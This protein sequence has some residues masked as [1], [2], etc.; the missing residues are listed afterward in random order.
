[1][2]Y[3]PYWNISGFEGSQCEYIS[4]LSVCKNHPCQN[5]GT[6]VNTDSS[7]LSLY[8]CLCKVGFHGEYGKKVLKFQTL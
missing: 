6:C 3:F 2:L 7:D 1:M 8:L 5:S 4:P